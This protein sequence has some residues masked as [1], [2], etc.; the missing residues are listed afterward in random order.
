MRA[1]NKSIDFIRAKPEQAI[2][3]AIKY[4]GMDEQTISR[5]MRNVEYVSNVNI[6][7]LKEYVKFLIGFGY[8]KL[9]NLQSFMEKIVY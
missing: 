9:N 7:G 5:A 3:V 8:I 2:Q 6:E 1:H 4:T